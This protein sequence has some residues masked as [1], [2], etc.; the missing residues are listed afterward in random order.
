MSRKLRLLLVDSVHESPESLLSELQRAGYAVDCQLVDGPEDLAAALGSPPWGATVVRNGAAVTTP[1]PEQTSAGRQIIYDY[2]PNPTFIWQRVG[3]SFVLAD[4]NEAAQIVSGDKIRTHLGEPTHTV[5][6]EFPLLADDLRACFDQ[7]AALR[8]EV[9][10]RHPPDGPLRH[11]ISTYGFL[12]PDRVLQHTE[13]VTEQR[14]TE[15]HLLRVQ[16][17][18]AIGQLAGGV[19]HDFNNL[20]TVING[21]ADVGIE[22][23]PSTDPLRLDLLEIRK[24]GEHAAGLTRQLLAFSRKQV[25]K[26]L[27][28]NLNTVIV[29]VEKMLRRLIGE[30]MDLVTVLDPALGHVNADPGQIEQVVINLAVNARD[31]MPN[32]GLLTLETANVD[33]DDAYTER[34]AGMWPGPYVRLSVTD[35]GMGMDAETKARL[36]EPFFTTKE[37]GRGT[38]L[39]LATVYGIVKQSGGSIWVYSEPGSGTSFKIYL[40]RVASQVDA[41]SLAPKPVARA[42]G[43]ETVLVVEDDEG[44]RRFTTRVLEA[45]GYRVLVAGNGHEALSLAQHAR[46]RVNLLITDVIMP[47]MN[48]RR[49]AERLAERWPA[50]QVIYVSGYTDATIVRHG[51]LDPGT[52]FVA[53]PFSA[54]ELT[55]KVRE[56]LDAGRD[57]P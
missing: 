39:G 34:H 22:S 11:I 10:F 12:P 38:G 15:D 44:V 57:R 53:K 17:L 19:A 13:D 47:H 52:Y 20:L 4:A 9:M 33:L 24:A 5:V 49:L 14:R 50:L 46:D 6:P 26:P 56:V 41:P 30:D 29:R 27:V 48:G 43:N 35:S 1:P 42:A 36:F 51:M 23:L 16:R 37:H 25:L 2:L 45:A 32:G 28:L 3:D 7:R 8:R 21:Y 55:N 18:E 31:A 40:P 54:V